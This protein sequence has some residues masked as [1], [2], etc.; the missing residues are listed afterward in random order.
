[1]RKGSIGPARAA[2][3]VA[4]ATL[5]ACAQAEA[6]SPAAITLEE[7]LRRAAA[8]H[9]DIAIA[10]ADVRAAEGEL[11][12][13]RTLPYNPEVAVGV[14][15]QKDEAGGAR[16]LDASLGQTIELGGKRSNRIKA[17]TARRAA[18]QARCEWVRLQVTARARRAHLLA[19][20]AAERVKTA[21]E[22]EEVADELRTAARERLDLGAGTQ[23]E[24]NVAAAAAG[25][26]RGERLA[27]ERLYRTARTELAAAIG[28]PGP[29][30]L[31][32]V[33]TLGSLAR[34]VLGE[35]ALVERALAQ[36]PDLTAVRQERAAAEAEVGLA[37]ALAVPDLTLGASYERSRD[38][39]RFLV[40]VSLPI[41][42]FNRNQGGKAV[43]NA[44][45]TRA[46]VTEEAARQGVQRDVRGAFRALGLARESV[47]GFDRDVVGSLGDNVSLAR[48]SFRA[49][50]ISLFDFNLLRRDL[51]ETQ[52]A[53]LDALAELVEARYA[54]ELAT[55]ASVE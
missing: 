14:A 25:R 21:R 50:K 4:M 22:A 55:G 12:S 42:F 20:A 33:G 41:P 27:A 32:P 24:V 6:S 13:A 45:R 54:L 17:A 39:T 35:E 16:D 19:L 7:A 15:P 9:P 43:A 30:D 8:S 52:L 1:M 29:D 28:F 18:V 40:G 3:G 38:D 11:V 5:Y 48:E 53:Y 36:R 23:L 49:G 31:E 34:P 46:T 44:L 47:E 10:E 37:G 26:A 51:V 2:F